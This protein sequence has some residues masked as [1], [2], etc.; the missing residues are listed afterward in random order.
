MRRFT[1]FAVLLLLVAACGSGQKVGSEKLTQ[2]KEASPA[3]RLGE[4]QATPSG[5]PGSLGLGGSTPTA[6]PTATPPAPTPERFFDVSMVADSPYFEP[7]NDLEMPVEFTLR[8]TN[9]DGTPERPG[10]SFTDKG[11]SFDSGLLKP[12]QVWT[13]KFSGTGRFQIED[14][15]LTFIPTTILT[16][17]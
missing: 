6:R 13:H 4:A 1:L 15:G 16:V 17:K 2:F 3:A 11:G 9:R 14:Q 7:G 8:V 10:R 5:D 12:G